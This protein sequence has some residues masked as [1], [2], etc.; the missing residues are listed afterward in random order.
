MKYYLKMIIIIY[1]YKGKIDKNSSK[2][3]IKLGIIKNK[4]ERTKAI[5]NNFEWDAIVSIQEYRDKVATA[6]A[7][8]EYDLYVN[9]TKLLWLLVPV[10]F[11][12]MIN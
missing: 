3:V 1:F 5:E 2:I 10:L 9:A 7:Q 4:Y 6:R 8:A 12:P 11:Q